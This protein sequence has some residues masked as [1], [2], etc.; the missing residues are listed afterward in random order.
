MD[1]DSRLRPTRRV[2][3]RLMVVD[4]GQLQAIILG[5]EVIKH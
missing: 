5:N 3:I 4:K 2:A 1:V